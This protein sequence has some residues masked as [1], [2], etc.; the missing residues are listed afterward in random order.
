MT[1]RI[2][3]T[4]LEGEKVVCQQGELKHSQLCINKDEEANHLTIAIANR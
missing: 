3:R 2:R 1:L 4:F